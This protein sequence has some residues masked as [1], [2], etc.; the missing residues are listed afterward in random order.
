MLVKLAMFILFL[1]LDFLERWTLKLKL[2][3][4]IFKILSIMSF[5]IIQNLVFLNIYILM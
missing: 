2:K 1:N 5:I 4:G 3:K